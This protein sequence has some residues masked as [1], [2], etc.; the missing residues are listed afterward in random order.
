MNPYQLIP[1]EKR[2][3]ILVATMKEF[4]EKGYYRASTNQIVQEAQISKGLIF[5]YFSNKKGLFLATYDYCVEQLSEKIIPQVQEQSTD[6]FERVLQ[7]GQLKLRLFWEHPLEYR[8]LM[9]AMADVPDD[10]AEV[11]RR[12]QE[13]SKVIHLPTV[14]EGVDLARFRRNVDPQKAI[15]FCLLSLEAFGNEWTKRLIRE[16]DKGLA[17]LEQA[18]QEMREFMEFLKYG[19]YEQKSG[20]AHR[21]D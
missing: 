7:I 16:P 20:E 19:V 9:S 5:H 14:L 21:H 18:V 10:I 11:I 13:Q 6:F 3:K 4:A 8:F 2:E 15:H 17:L 1:K 12:R